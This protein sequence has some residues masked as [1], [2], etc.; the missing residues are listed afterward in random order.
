[1][2]AVTEMV[3]VSNN[4]L[5]AWE[6]QWVELVGSQPIIERYG[7]QVRVLPALNI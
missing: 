3:Y 5:A 2:S 4:P 1:M 7:L 6:N